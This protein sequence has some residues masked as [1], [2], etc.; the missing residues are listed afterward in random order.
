MYSQLVGGKELVTL[1]DETQLFQL[2][3]TMED[4]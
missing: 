3:K 4:F 2:I 1:M